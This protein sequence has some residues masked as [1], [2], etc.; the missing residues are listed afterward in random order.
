MNLGVGYVRFSRLAGLVGLVLVGWLGNALGQTA[1]GDQVLFPEVARRG[2]MP[3]TVTICVSR[4]RDG[5]LA[6]DGADGPR[7]LT[8]A[9]SRWVEERIESGAIVEPG[10]LTIRYVIASSPGPPGVQ[11]IARSESDL[12]V[13]GGVP[14]FDLP[15]CTVGDQSLPERVELGFERVVIRDPSSLPIRF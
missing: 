4:T 7:F 6:I 1:A 2:H 14:V 10:L 3:G 9:A 15:N 12:L 11:A 5:G 13:I 8:T